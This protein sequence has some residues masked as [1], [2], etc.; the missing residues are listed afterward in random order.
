MPEPR[1]IVTGL[2]DLVSE[3]IE[4][5]ERRGVT[6]ANNQWALTVQHPP[7]N[8]IAILRVIPLKPSHLTNERTIVITPPQSAGNLLFGSSGISVPLPLPHLLV[9]SHPVG[10][11]STCKFNCIIIPVAGCFRFDLRCSWLPRCE[12]VVHHHSTPF[13]SDW[14]GTVLLLLVVG[15]VIRSME[16]GKHNAK[17]SDK[18]RAQQTVVDP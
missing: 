13:L 4:S 8:A 11:K 5:K 2:C 12:L 18:H 9:H 7:C 14:N 3:I 1:P 6:Y 17:D 15:T 10:Y 16:S